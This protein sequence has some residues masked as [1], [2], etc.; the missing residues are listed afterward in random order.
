MGDVAYV[1]HLRQ[2]NAARLLVLRIETLTLSSA[3]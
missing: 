3:S 1:Q 2:G